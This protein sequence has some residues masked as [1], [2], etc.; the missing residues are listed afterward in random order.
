[1]EWRLKEETFEVG[2]TP[3][4][5]NPEEFKRNVLLLSELHPLQTRTRWSPEPHYPSP[6]SPDT[7]VGTLHSLL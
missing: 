4:S 3:I 7:S 1:M 5:R 6:L 2:K